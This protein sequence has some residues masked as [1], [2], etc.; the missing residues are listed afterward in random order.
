MY[1]K[2]LIDEKCFEI[3]SDLDK[4]LNDIFRKGGKHLEQTKNFIR[5]GYNYDYARTDAVAYCLINILENANASYGKEP[6]R[7]IKTIFKT[8]HIFDYIAEYAGD[9]ANNCGL[10]FPFHEWGVIESWL[11]DA[12]KE[13]EMNGIRKAYKEE[14]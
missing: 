8:E 2:E 12:I 11:P 10:A 9:D 14:M 7:W 4:Y 1:S 3:K 6:P 13:Y 5:H